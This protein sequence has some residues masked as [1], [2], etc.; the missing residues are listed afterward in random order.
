M[1]EPTKHYG[2][3]RIRWIDEN[4]K[5]CSSVFE[6]Y[7]ESKAELKRIEYEVE[8]IKQGLL[9]K[10][11]QQITFKELA[12]YWMKY[13]AAYK[14]SQKDDVSILRCHLLPAFENKPIA[15][16]KVADIDCLNQKLKHLSPKTV[17]NILT[18]L[19]SML[20]MAVELDW[21]S[22]AP[23]IKK[24]STKLF[25]KDFHYLRTPEEVQRFLLSAKEEDEMV[26]VMY[27]TAVFSGLRA[28]EIAALRFSDFDFEKS[29]MTIQ[30]SYNGPTKSDRVRYVPIMSA[31]RE[32]LMKWRLKNPTEIVFPNR[33]G[34]QHQPSARVFQEILHRVLDRAEFPKKTV[35]GKTK[36]YI[37]FHG[38][39]HTFSSHWMMNGGDLFKLQRV[40]GHQD[41]KMTQRYAHLSPDAFMDDLNRLDALSIAESDNI[42]PFK[43]NQSS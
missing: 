15:Q 5:R 2:K 6:T 19:G 14:R 11:N 39:R 35:N 27:A 26:Y 9:K 31:L 28:G 22:K 10:D 24:P 13:R 12:D 3:F 18:L 43:L 30:R 16:I 29:I 17:F 25:S 21:L 23:L 20:K 8:Q 36:Y 7:K 33:D 40:L 38:S 34:R 41:S 1:A 42:I 4:G 37:T 32:I